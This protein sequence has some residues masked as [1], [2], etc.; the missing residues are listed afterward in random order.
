MR[1]F[2]FISLNQWEEFAMV[3]LL[4]SKNLLQ[5]GWIFAMV[6]NQKTM[7]LIK[8]YGHKILVNFNSFLLFF[9]GHF[10]VPM[11]PKR[12]AE[13]PSTGGQIKK[14]AQSECESHIGL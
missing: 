5:N 4:Q 14:T 12:N 10:E 3:Y 8:K 1:G 13:T 6:D 7:G 11:R 2:W 9:A